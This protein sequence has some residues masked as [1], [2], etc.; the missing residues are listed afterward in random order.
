MDSAAQ[1][2][3]MDVCA[4]MSFGVDVP[5]RHP[6]IREFMRLVQAGTLDDQ[7][8]LRATA[9]RPE[10]AAFVQGRLRFAA[11]PKWIVPEVPQSLYEIAEEMCVDPAELI[12]LWRE[13]KV[14]FSAGRADPTPGHE[15]EVFAFL[16]LDPDD[17]D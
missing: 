3:I 2:R 15:A 12:H 16:G 1:D 8:G 7:P 13:G 17:E 14:D 10:S 11:A 9:S 5:T 6:V 4:R